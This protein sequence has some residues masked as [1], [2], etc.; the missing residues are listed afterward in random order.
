M[1]RPLKTIVIIAICAL[2]IKTYQHYRLAKLTHTHQQLA[3]E[4]A[5][6]MQECIHLHQQYEKESS[7]ETLYTD[8]LAKGMKRIDHTSIINLTKEKL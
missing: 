1:K 4:Q 6:L 3:L 8:A 2:V 7:T 5:S